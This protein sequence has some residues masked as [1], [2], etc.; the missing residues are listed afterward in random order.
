VAS[1]SLRILVVEDDADVA[2]VIRRSLEAL[3]HLVT[4]ESNAEA[5]LAAVKAGSF[6][7]VLM[8]NSLPGAMGIT[9]LPE[10]VG[11]SPAPVVMMTGHPNSDVETD[12]LLLGAKALVAKPFE[13]GTIEAVLE[14]A[15][16]K[17]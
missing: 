16:G 7:L 3:G 11:A 5:G 17:G 15:V 2:L 4:H 14:K 9:L 12:A 1:K 10:F 8:D 6:D 13:P